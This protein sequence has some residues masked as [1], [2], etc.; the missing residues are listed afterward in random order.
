MRDGTNQTVN[1]NLYG[2]EKEWV[3][4]E[5]KHHGADYIRNHQRGVDVDDA[6]LANLPP[7]TRNVA[8]RTYVEGT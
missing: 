1:C 6:L 2:F 4:D 3:N 5:R 7:R 8:S